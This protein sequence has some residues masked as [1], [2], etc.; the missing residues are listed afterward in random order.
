MDQPIYTYKS[1][2]ILSANVHP[3]RPDHIL[4]NIT[5]GNSIQIQDLDWKTKALSPVTLPED[6]KEVLMAN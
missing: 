4:L 2:R 3:D 5:Y 1:V 6:Y